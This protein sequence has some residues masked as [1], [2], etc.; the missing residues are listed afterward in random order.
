MNDVVDE[1]GELRPEG[2]A[3]P[4]IGIDWDGEEK[5][6]NEAGEAG[7]HYINHK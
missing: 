2:K 7:V 4:E 6:N 5:T 1:S 3:Q